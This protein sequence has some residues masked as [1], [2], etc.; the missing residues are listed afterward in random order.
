MNKAQWAED[1]F[2]GSI[3]IYTGVDRW[4]KQSR[5]WITRFLMEEM[6]CKKE[7]IIF[8]KLWCEWSCF[9]KI[10]EQWWYFSSGDPRLACPWFLVR[11][12]DGPKDYTGK[13]NLRVYYG[14]QDFVAELRDVLKTGYTQNTFTSLW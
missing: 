11:K 9:A 2:N 6:G 10:G 1:Y 4:I 8:K 13:G 7:D 3:E 12:A 5:T 14:S